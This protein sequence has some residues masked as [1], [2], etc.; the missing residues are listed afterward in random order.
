MPV[1]GTKLHVPAM[2]RRDAGPGCDDAE[3]GAQVR[4]LLRRQGQL[5]AGPD[6]GGEGARAGTRATPGGGGQLALPA[7]GRLVEIA[8]DRI[9]PDGQVLVAFGQVG[10]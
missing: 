9:E 5:R 10:P 6:C 1:L 2:R 4:L 8:R 7:P 3:R